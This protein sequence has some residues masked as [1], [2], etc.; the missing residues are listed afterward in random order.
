MK[1]DVGFDKNG[2]GGRDD[3]I[4][5]FNFNEHFAAAV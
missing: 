4:I 2:M 3:Q 5:D 1:Q